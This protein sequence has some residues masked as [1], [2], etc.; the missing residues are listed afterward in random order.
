[1]TDSPTDE[2]ETPK[3]TPWVNTAPRATKFQ[4]V[5]ASALTNAGPLPILS[6]AFETIEKQMIT[7]SFIADDSGLKKMKQVFLRAYDDALREVK[8]LRRSIEDEEER[9]RNA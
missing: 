9:E 4:I 1:M 2:Q 8:L 5:A 7:V 6:F 3:P